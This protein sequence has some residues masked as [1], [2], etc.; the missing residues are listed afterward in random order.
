MPDLFLVT[1]RTYPVRTVTLAGVQL[2]FMA[3]KWKQKIQRQFA[4]DVNAVIQG[5]L[6]QDLP[7]RG[8]QGF[9]RRSLM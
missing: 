5:E 7:P 2:P 3:V 1:V 8:P 9:V 4:G 6:C